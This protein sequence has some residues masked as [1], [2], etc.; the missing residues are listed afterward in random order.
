MKVA[1]LGEIC[2]MY[3]PKT[4]STKEMVSNGKYTVFGANGAIGKY[5]KYNHESPQLLV[6]CRGATCG[7]V[8][9]SEP[10]SWINGNAMVVKPKENL[11]TFDYLKY[12]FLGGIDVSGAITGSAQ[13]QITRT[14]L[15]QILIPIPSIDYQCLAVEKL[16]KA[17]SE[18]DSLEKNLQLKEEK[19]NQLLQSMLS[20]AFTYSEEFN[21]KVAKLGDICS[22]INGLWTGKKPPFEKVFVI[23][24]TNFTKDCKLNLENV[25]ELSVETKQLATRKLRS[26]DLI[27]EKSGGGPK[28][29]VGR[30]VLFSEEG[31]NFSLSNFTSALRIKDPSK[32][33]P[34]FIQLFLFLQY[35]LGKTETMQSNSTGIRNLN[36]NQFLD[37]EIPIPSI[38]S[39]EEIVN[40]L[41]KAFAEIKKIINQ[42][43]IEKE[44]VSTLRQS[45]LGNAFNFSE[46]AA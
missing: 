11:V 8:N 19:T 7:S 34:K 4:I 33:I 24:N 40:R 3:Q 41:D 35:I 9:I 28:Q 26:G 10:F 31:E 6:T 38:E 39:Q 44:R 32:F 16:D 20:A 2:E 25:A 37:I 42:I 15:E 45:I 12:A 27:V 43:S 22:T 30:V 46:K 1:K 5:D 13:P 18:I 36:M 17:F 21:V 29:A 23:R 14:T